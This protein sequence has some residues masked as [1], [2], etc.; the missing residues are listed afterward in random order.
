MTDENGCVY[1]LLEPTDKDSPVF[2]FLE[3]RI[4]LYHFCYEVE[5]LEEKLKELIKKGFYLIS[6]PME[7]IAFKGRNIAFLIDREN[8]IIELVEQ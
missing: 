2:G 6:G 5:N 7:A 3:K 1:E 4:S 8:L